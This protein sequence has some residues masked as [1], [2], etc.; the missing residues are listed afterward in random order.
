MTVRIQSDS[1]TVKSRVNNWEETLTQQHLES[2][3]E[4]LDK[5]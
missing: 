5:T 1:L 2:R 3:S 4:R